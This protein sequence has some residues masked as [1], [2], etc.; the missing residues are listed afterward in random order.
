MK[1]FFRPF[2]ATLALAFA[3]A[4]PAAAAQATPVGTWQGRLEVAP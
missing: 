2:L 3:L 1:T 4:G